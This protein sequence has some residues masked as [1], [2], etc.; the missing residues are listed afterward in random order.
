M[1]SAIA[2]AAMV[3]A[4][5]WSSASQAVEL[6]LSSSVNANLSGY[7]NGSVYPA[8]G[9]P[10]TIGG[11]NFNLAQYPGGG[12]G[13]VQGA[14]GNSD[15]INL[16]TFIGTPLVYSVVNSAFGVPGS[17]I[18]ELVF[19]A[20]G[21][22]TFAYVYTEGDNVRDHASTQY[23]TVAPN[24]YATDDFGSGDRLDVQQIVL[25]ADFLG[26]TVDVSLIS[27][28]N[29]GGD[30]FVAA[31]TTMSAVPEPSTWAMMILGF[32]GVG[33]MAYRRKNG[34]LRLA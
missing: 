34:A 5:S 9:G 14:D 11:I 4:F 29:G 31:I 12:T 15:N 28:D 26:L 16:G 8:N 22:P 25:P 23:N 19:S 2:C 32:F 27:F 24:V 7:F 3:L 30:P 1:R 13:V 33:F 20:A 6:D 21:V 17:Q 18:G 10:I